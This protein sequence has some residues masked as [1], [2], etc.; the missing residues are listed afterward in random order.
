[1][2]SFVLNICSICA[3]VPLHFW[4]WWLVPSLCLSS[5]E[6][7]H[8][9]THFISLLT[10]S[11]FGLNIHFDW[12]SFINFCSYLCYFLYCTFLE[13]DVI[14]FLTSWDEC[15]GRWLSAFFFLICEFKT[16]HFT[17][18]KTLFTTHKFTC[19]VFII[20]RLKIFF[21]FLLLLILWLTSYLEERVLMIFLYYWWLA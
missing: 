6:T 11:T 14:V 4:C 3:D 17:L 2:F 9:F 21:Q 15:L 19:S 20:L 8:G 18:S 16:I 10:N 13:F 12:F 1:M 7:C 5:S